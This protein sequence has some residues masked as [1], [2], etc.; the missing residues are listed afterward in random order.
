[1]ADMKKLVFLD[2]SHNQLNCISIFLV[3]ILLN[4]SANI[5]ELGALTT[6]RVLDLSS[7]P[8]LLQSGAA[9]HAALGR[10]VYPTIQD[11]AQLIKVLGTKLTKMEYLAMDDI[12]AMSQGQVSIK[13]TSFSDLKRCSAFFPQAWLL[14][15]GK[16]DKRGTLSPHVDTIPF[17]QRILVC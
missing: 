16:S 15:L 13:L 7:N 2:L 6:L 4:V 1:M 11:V 10:K 14:Q 9:P 5:D 17:R 3:L 8:I 12:P